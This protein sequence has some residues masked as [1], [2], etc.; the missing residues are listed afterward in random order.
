MNT[1]K[2]ALAL[3]SGGAR[4][5]YEVG[6]IRF[7]AEQGLRFNAVSGASIGALNGAYYAQGDG[8]PDA[9]QELAERWLAMPSVGIIQ[10][11][12]SKV[13]AL[14]A[15]LV[16]KELPLMTRM[17]QMLEIGKGGLLDPRP[18]ETL[19]DNWIDYDAVRKSKIDLWIAVLEETEP[20]LDIAMYTWKKA[21]YFQAADCNT[22]SKLRSALLASAAIPFAFPARK[23][24]IEKYADAGLVDPLPAQEL[25]RRG[26]RRIV[27]VFLSDD[28]IQNRVDFPNTIL[29]QIRPS[30]NID[31]GLMS[32]FDFSRQSIERL[33]NLG[34]RDAE[35]CF[36]E[37][38]DTFE[39]LLELKRLGDIEEK[40]ADAL[41]NRHHR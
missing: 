2:M 38:Q 12:A 14:L 13:V 32:C 18:I 37:T 7:L 15:S 29:L 35:S 19:I 23:V 22:S 4:G 26:H 5:A 34:Y 41:P 33:M 40:L 9:I 10:M 31:A 16:A 20:L 27:S 17:L 8:S 24:G 25:Y 21:T 30:V 11:D 36:K 6:V 28:T 1:N 3:S 39:R